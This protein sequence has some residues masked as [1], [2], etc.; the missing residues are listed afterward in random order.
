MQV[1]TVFQVAVVVAASAAAV[2]L[3]NALSPVIV[4]AIVIYAGMDT[5]VGHSGKA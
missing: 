2:L 5:K 1:A 4:S 3:F